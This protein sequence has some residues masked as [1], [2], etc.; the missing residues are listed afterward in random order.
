VA[1]DHGSQIALAVAKRLVVVAQ[2]QGGQSQF[3]PFLTAPANSASPIAKV[4]AYVMEHIGGT[5]P[6]EKLAEVAGMSPRSFA[7]VFVAETGVTPHEFIDRARIDTAR[8][9]LEGGDLPL[10]AVAYHAGFTSADR[11]RLV[12]AKQ[13]GISPA[14]YRANFQHRP[15]S[16]A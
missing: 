4:Q 12:F 10:K 7:R 15:T 13:L 5:L 9:L 3:S 16:V 1:E 6:V 14:Q 8:N 2:R 11:M